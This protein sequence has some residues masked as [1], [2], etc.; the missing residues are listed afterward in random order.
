MHARIW[1]ILYIGGWVTSYCCA[2][3]YMVYTIYRWMGDFILLCMPVYGI[4][5]IYGWM[6]DFILLCMPVYGIYYI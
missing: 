5:Y 3:P 2:S 6:G 4:Y 1:Y